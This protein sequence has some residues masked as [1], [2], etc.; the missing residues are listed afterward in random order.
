MNGSDAATSAADRSRVQ[1]AALRVGLWVGLGSV[2]VLGAITAITVAV[3]LGSSRARPGGPSG[4]RHER[5]EDRIIE[6]DDIVPLAIVLGVVG[7]LLLGLIA[8]LAARR[9]S[10]PL[11]DALSAQRTFVADAS[12]E[13]RTPLTTLT[14]RIQLAQHR[15][16]RGADVGPVLA[17]LRRDATVM[18]AVLND[19]LLTAES[20]GATAADAHAI[21]S[22]DLAARDAV[23]II[24]PRAAEGGV[25][26]TV[27]PPAGLDVAADHTALTRALVALLDN[28]VRHSP[29]GST[30]A[31]SARSAGRRAELRVADQGGGIVGIEPGR[32][33]DRFARAETGTETGFETAPDARRGFG[34]G[35]ALVKEVVMRFGGTVEVEHTS[36]AGTTFLLTLPLR[37]ARPPS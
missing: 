13:L 17:D 28:A 23:G 16:E 19:L 15:A 8:W 32:V 31:V 33:F 25:A 18:D 5:W 37:A 29:P 26:L 14:S 27:S 3:M 34:L 6:L 35:L 10:R 9:A 30:V 20:A 4:R 7:V 11:A 12:H 21:A 24:G 36:P 22:V 1:R 2:A